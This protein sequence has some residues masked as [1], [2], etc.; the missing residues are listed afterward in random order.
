MD[1]PHII[2]LAVVG[3]AA[4]TDLATRRVPNLLTFGGAVL[5]LVFHSATNG[6]AGLMHGVTGWFVGVSLFLPFF[7][8]RGLGAGDVKLLGAVGA[9]LGP[10]GAL[11]SGFLSVVAGG[12]LAVVIGLK[13]RYLRQAF[14]NLLGMFA[15]W[16]AT[17]L[18]NVPGVTIQDS[19]GPRLAYTTAIAAGTLAAVWWA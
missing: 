12:V 17:G 15:L 6:T 16:H 9:W 8:L 14:T 11:H 2:V 5:A 18:R 4:A 10:I 19:K 1:A 7:V 3:V 13:H